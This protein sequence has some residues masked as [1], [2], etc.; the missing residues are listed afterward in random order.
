[1]AVPGPRM[2]SPVVVSPRPL[3]IVC[4]LVLS[5]GG[6][7]A[8]F[9]LTSV[10][11]ARLCLLVVT[12]TRSGDDDAVTEDELISAVR[13]AA[14]GRD[15]PPPAPPE[16][17]A[18]AEAVIGFQLPPLLRR[19]YVEVANGGFG[20]AFGVLGIRVPGGLNEDIT[21]PYR[22]G[23]DPAVVKVPKGLVP[24]CDWGCAMLSMVDFR[25]P[26]GPMWGIEEGELFREGMTLAGW[27]ERYLDGSL[28][29]P[30]AHA[31]PERIKI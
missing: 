28:R 17:V 14:E 8:D 22:E 25:D 27:L 29:S 16:V 6:R 20:P 18:E 3:L 26:A 9:L 10:V 5:V 11:D 30:D 15:L 4:R 31:H 23:W 12:R 7:C 1:M 2:M 21:D 13:A 19:L 24:L